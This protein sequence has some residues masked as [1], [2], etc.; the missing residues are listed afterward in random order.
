MKILMLG[1]EYPPHINGGLG[2]ACAGI[3]KALSKFLDMDLIFALPRLYGDE[4]AG[5]IRLLEPKSEIEKDNQESAK[6]I[7]R[8]FFPYKLNPYLTKEESEKLFINFKNDFFS[9]AEKAGFEKLKKNVDIDFEAFMKN[10]KLALE[11]IRYTSNLI[12]FFYNKDFDL[13]HAHDWMTI[14]A[15]MVISKI[16]KKPLVL[17][18]HSLEYDRSGVVNDFFINKI[19]GMGVN[20]ANKVIAVSEYTKGIIQREHNVRAE[21]IEVVYNAVIHHRKKFFSLSKNLKKYKFILFLGRIT[22]QKGP[23]YFVDASKKVIEKVKN[24]RFIMAGAGDLTGEMM[25][26]VARLGLEDYFIFT[27]FLSHDEV[28]KVFSIAD[29][30]V[31]PSFSEPFGIVALEAIDYG[32]PIIV[33]KQS[34]VSEVIKSALQCDYWD[35]EKIGDFIIY[36]LKNSKERNRLI[37]KSK[38]ESLCLSW[39][40]SAKKIY[41]IYQELILKLSLK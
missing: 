9:I 7:T 34:G 37:K 22:S 35:S 33:S 15:G 13:V 17:H 19:E 24:V 36:L 30:F 12:E 16:S 25:N 21:N 31:M 23:E 20:F 5:R 39:D 29:V 11:V 10:N 27:G 14:L 32:V 38:E 6:N 3:T 4:Y 28:R 8:I 41:N 1:W 40:L 26:R 18:I 2:T